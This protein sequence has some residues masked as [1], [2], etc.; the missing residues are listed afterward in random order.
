MSISVDPFH[1]GGSKY[2]CTGRIL[3]TGSFSSVC[4]GAREDGTPVA[5]KIL[6]EEFMKQAK[7]NNQLQKQM[8]AEIALMRMMEHENI[9]HIFD[10]DYHP[11]TSQLCII[12]EFC[13]YGHLGRYLEQ[14][15]TEQ[16]PEGILLVPEAKH[17]FRHLA[18]G[19]K[20]LWNKNIVHRDLKPEN[21]L[22]TTR[23]GSGQPVHFENIV[24]KIGDFGL[25]RQV[26]QF[27]MTKCGTYVYMAPERENGG[28]YTYKSDLWS[29][30]VILYQALTGKRFIGLIDPDDEKELTD[31]DAKALLQGLLQRHPDNR[32]MWREFYLHPFMEI[33]NDL[34]PIDIKTLPKIP[35][36]P[37]DQGAPKSPKTLQQTSRK[38]SNS[39]T[40]TPS[41]PRKEIS[42]SSDVGRTRKSASK[43]RTSDPPPRKN[44]LPDNKLSDREASALAV[45]HLIKQK[46][47]FLK[48]EQEAFIVYVVLLET[49]SKLKQM[50]N[51]VKSSIDLYVKDIKE[52]AQRISQQILRN[53]PAETAES[54]LLRLALEC[55]RT[56]MQKDREENWEEAMG[57]YMQGKHCLQF[58]EFFLLDDD[59][60]RSHQSLTTQTLSAFNSRLDHI[61]PLINEK[62]HQTITST[63]ESA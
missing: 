40:F 45:M 11:E 9:V 27:A 36:G 56:A 26:E 35:S 17:L 8:L 18:L 29:I 34:A 44:L 55:G 47:V 10:T 37:T 43:R 15:A 62:Q 39:K 31:E 60:T 19:Y 13:N 52:R 50:R 38:I 32:F 57:L 58:I 1:L 20:Q 6:S 33:P 42:A 48:Q 28:P 14:R 63:I 16:Y 22:L 21:L 12:L 54:I 51:D 2:Y 4:A 25:A 3:G 49:F 30:G 61:L 7:V 59:D 24:L 23:E 5:I 53:T 41:S 46:E